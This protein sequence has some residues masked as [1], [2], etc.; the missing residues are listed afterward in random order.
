MASL[1][2]GY[3]VFSGSSQAGTDSSVAGTIQAET[4]TQGL[5]RIAIQRASDSEFY[6]AT[7]QA[8][9]AGA[10]AEADDL[11]FA[12]STSDR[13]IHPT[14]RRLEERLPKEAAQGIDADGA[15]FSIYPDGSKG[16][17]SPAEQDITIGFKPTT[18]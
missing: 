9:Q 2:V 8:Y 5:H 7:T 4:A 14:I 1:R 17:G 18:L 11:P 12:G 6:N 15:T 16:A 13:G 10:V 3:N